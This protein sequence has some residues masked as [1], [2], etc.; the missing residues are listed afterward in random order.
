MYEVCLAKFTQHEDFLYQFHTVYRGKCDWN[1]KEW[2]V[3]NG[4]GK[5][6][7]GEILIRIKGELSN[8]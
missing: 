4:E 8:A 6:K 2:G 1:D 5:N 7:L 3:Y